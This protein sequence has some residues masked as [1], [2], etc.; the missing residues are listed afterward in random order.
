[1]TSNPWL[2]SRHQSIL[3]VYAFVFTVGCF[4]VASIGHASVITSTTLVT[5]VAPPGGGV[6]PGATTGSLPIV[7][8]ETADGVFTSNMPVDA[9]YTSDFTAN[10]VVSGPVVNA[11]LVSGVI[12][13]GTHYDSYFFHFDP[14]GTGNYPFSGSNPAEI[15][16]SSQILGLQLFGTGV[17]SPRPATGTLGNGDAVSPFGTAYY[18]GSVSS[19]GVESGDSLQVYLSGTGLRLAGTVSG[20]EIDQIRIFVAVPE[21]NS[22]FLAAIGL[23][24]LSF[25]GI[26][27]VGAFRRA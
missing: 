2:S 19:R 5:Q 14:N 13:A 15:D 11:N 24:G 4:A 20:G 1:M 3:F 25:L 26:K 27:K 21:P 22:L 7:F 17:N 9:L 23:L 8:Q 18:P 10:P 12:P 6:T 16:F